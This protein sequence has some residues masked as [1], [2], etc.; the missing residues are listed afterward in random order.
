MESGDG[1]ERPCKVTSSF[2]N[3]SLRSFVGRVVSKGEALKGWHQNRWTGEVDYPLTD[4]STLE[5]GGVV[6]P[7]PEF[8]HGPAFGPGFCQEKDRVSMD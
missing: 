3:P 6:S 8:L 1:R 2:S 5:V 4:K 7:T